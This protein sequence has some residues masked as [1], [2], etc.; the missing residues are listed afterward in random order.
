MNMADKKEMNNKAKV[1]KK[2]MEDHHIHFI[3]NNDRYR[4]KFDM[5]RHQ[6]SY[7]LKYLVAIGYLEPRDKKIYQ[8]PFNSN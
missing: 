4:K 8:T 7:V 5:N 2:Y 3:R 1:V 6:F